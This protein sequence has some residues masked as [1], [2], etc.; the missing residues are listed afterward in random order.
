MTGSVAVFFAT[1][2]VSGGLV[3]LGGGIGRWGFRSTVGSHGAH[4]FRF[5]EWQL[6]GEQSN[7]GF[8]A[9]FW[10][11]LKLS[12]IEKG[13]TNGLNSVVFIFSIFFQLKTL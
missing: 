6:P 1:L 3:F 12:E 4:P 5:K 10:G 8:R 2:L 7:K 9:F 11:G 13:K